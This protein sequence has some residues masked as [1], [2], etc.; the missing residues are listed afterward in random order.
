MLLLLL[1][2]LFA[3]NNADAHAPRAPAHQARRGILTVAT[4]AAVTVAAAAVTGALRLPLWQVARHGLLPAAAAAPAGAR[5]AVPFPFVLG[6]RQVEGQ[7]E[8][9][10]ARRLLLH[11][12]GY[13]VGGEDRDALKVKA[14]QGSGLGGWVEG[15]WMVGM[16]VRVR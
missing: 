8:G 3:T 2:L 13:L 4:A 6:Q 1:L 14:T 5:A 12:R 7:G 11:Q 15:V 16:A 9:Q 10:A